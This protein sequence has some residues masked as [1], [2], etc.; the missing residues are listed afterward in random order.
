M[1]RLENS[2]EQKFWEAWVKDDVFFCWRFGKLGASGHT[3]L[4]K[5]GSKNL[6]DAELEARL[7]EKLHEGYVELGTPPLGVA[8]AR[9]SSET[10][11][12]PAPPR[13]G[14]RK[15]AA[16]EP[17]PAPP[18]PLPLRVAS[19]NPSPAELT[20]ALTALDKLLAGL[21]DRSWR[22][23]LLARH[24]HRAI[25]RIAGS[26]PAKHGLLGVSFDTLMA[27]VLGPDHP[28]PLRHALAL[29]SELDAA[30]FVR[31][32]RTWRGKLLALASSAA[33]AIGV[34]ATVLDAVSDGELALQTG[35]ALLDRNLSVDMWHRRFALIRPALEG[36]LSNKGSSL[37][38]LLASLNPKDDAVLAARLAEASR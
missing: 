16:P 29:L 7:G 20:A 10:A 30:V 6:A 17:P 15:A 22:V 21:D 2:S 33:P 12:D 18:P 24:A 38:L 3:K 23:G 36:A 8:T 28:L 25:E 11:S 31:A 35:L 27:Q 13:R 14:K 19:R 26:D 34:L 5:F 32:L 9:D 1:R 4:K 37:A